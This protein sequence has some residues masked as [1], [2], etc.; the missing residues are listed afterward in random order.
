MSTNY[1]GAEPHGPLQQISE[2]C[3]YVT[4][5]VMFKPLLRLPRNMI[6]LRHKD[7]LTLINSVR[8]DE[9]G[10]RSLEALGKIAHIMTIGFHQMD[11]AYYLNK[12]GATQWLVPGAD[13]NP[14]ARQTCQLTEN[15][16]LPVPDMR[17]F[18]F[19]ETIKGEAALLLERDGGLLIT[20]DSVQHWM[21]SELMSPLAKL[22]TRMIG[23]QKPAQ[24]GPPWRK[25]QT[26][27]GGSLRGDFERLLELPFE[28]LIGGHGGLL[29]SAAHDALAMSVEREL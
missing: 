20:C 6:I 12:Y 15:A 16:E 29:E 11:D 17:V 14:E 21:P 4:G 5:T 22:V 13:A 25:T 10:D 18:L 3:W 24:I 7:M 8:P 23:F 9:A 27:P 1:L 26:P 19:K 28:R 2:D